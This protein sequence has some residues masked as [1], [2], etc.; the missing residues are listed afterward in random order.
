MW[1]KAR[2]MGRQVRIEFTNHCTAQGIQMISVFIWPLRLSKMRH[3]V[4]LKQS[5]TGFPSPWPVA[6]PRLKSPVCPTNLL[7]AGREIVVFVPFP[8]VLAQWEM[9]TASSRIWTR[10]AVFI[11]YDGIH[12]PTNAYIYIYILRKKVKGRLV[13]LAISSNN[14]PACTV[15]GLTFKFVAGL[16]CPLRH[17]HKNWQESFRPHTL[18]QT[19]ESIIYIIPFGGYQFV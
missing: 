19:R 7:L 15:S 13:T 14:S 1:C 3:Q 12:Y 10:V 2:N 11:S 17:S 6:V 9:K 4:I 8:R 18:K 16:K 5:L